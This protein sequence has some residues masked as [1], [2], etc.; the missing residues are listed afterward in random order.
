M[1]LHCSQ[2][3]NDEKLTRIGFDHPMKLHCSQTLG[4]IADNELGFDHPMKLHCSQTRLAT[5][6]VC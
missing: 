4:V 3:S 2:T 5:N 6:S 1:K